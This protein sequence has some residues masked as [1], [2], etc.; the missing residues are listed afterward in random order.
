MNDMVK[1]LLLWL[2]IAAVLLTVFQN[3]N[4]QPQ[5][6][7]L[8]YSEFLEQVQG[9]RVSKV[10]I[11]G[12]LI[13]GEREDGSR[14]RCGLRIAQPHPVR[15]GDACCLDG[16]LVCPRELL[17]EVEGVD[18]FVRGEILVGAQELTRRRL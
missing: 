18:P 16:G 14:E 8:N 13:V 3:F 1:N 15:A 17:G 11:D 6:E 2:I 10:T 5:R 4:M 9:D 12:L 7:Q